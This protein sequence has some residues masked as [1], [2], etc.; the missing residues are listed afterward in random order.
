MGYQT[1]RGK[2]LKTACILRVL[3]ILALHARAA[4]ATYDNKDAGFAMRMPSGWFFYPKEAIAQS[5]G[6]WAKLE[7]TPPLREI[8]A[9]VGRATNLYYESF[10]RIV[11]VWPP[12]IPSASV[13]FI[14]SQFAQQ[15]AGR[16]F[17]IFSVHPV[18]FPSLAALVLA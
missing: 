6:V 1:L 4:D 14:L 18:T 3:T 11:V 9:F 5:Y 7:P 8:A 12:A 16:L 13:T 2:V 10:P 15:T 17:L